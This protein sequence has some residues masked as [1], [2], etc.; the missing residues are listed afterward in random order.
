LI[1]FNNKRRNF[2]L[3]LFYF[4]AKNHVPQICLKKTHS[5]RSLA[6]RRQRREKIAWRK[7]PTSGKT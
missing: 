6:T 5:A 7:S 4:P 1:L 3:R 2:F